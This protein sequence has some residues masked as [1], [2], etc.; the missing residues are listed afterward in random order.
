MVAAENHRR[1][2]AGGVE[3][4]GGGR[5]GLSGS[6]IRVAAVGITPPNYK[7][8][9][10]I[11]AAFQLM[12]QVANLCDARM[13]VMADHDEDQLRGRLSVT[14]RRPDNILAS[15]ESLLPRQVTSMMWRPRIDE[16]LE[17]FSPAVVHFHNPHPA[18]ALAR[19]ARHCV[20]RGIPYVISTHGFVEFNDF[21]KGFGSPP[22]QRPLLQRFVRRPLMRVAQEAARVFMLSP[23]ERPTLLGM[24]VKEHRLRV[25]PNGVDP[26]FLEDVPEPERIK[27]VSRFQLPAGAP[28]LF[29]VGNHT[30]NKG[31]DVLLRALPMMREN[32]VAIIAGAIRSR[33]ENEKLVLSSGLALTDKRFLFTDFISKEELRAL[34]HSVN[35]FVFPSRADTLPLVILEAMAC[36]LPVVAT[37][38]GGIPYEVTADEGIL[39]PPGEPARLAEALDR[40]CADHETAE[41]MGASGRR[42]VITH[43]DWSASAALAVSSYTDIIE[44][45][46]R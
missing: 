32:A 8:S 6:G 26:Y 11:S 1:K 21:S 45:L 42:R 15:L 17:E 18:G 28:L 4:K 25:V 30:H 40:V 29:F 46:R 27:L 3:R 41:R 39:V 35:A 23:Y 12:E 19:V 5:A 7:A 37:N 20:K 43:F 10:G 14:M 2:S 44:P 24:G 13:F 34:Y 36:R 31:I 9:G 38:V 33:P 22:W 16:W